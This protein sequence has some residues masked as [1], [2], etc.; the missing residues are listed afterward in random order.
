[1]RVRVTAAIILG[2]A[3]SACGGGP[4]NGAP[5]MVVGGQ[6]IKLTGHVYVIADRRVS[7]VPNVGIVVGDK[8]VLVIDTG[9]GPANAEI[10]LAEVRKI[11]DLPIQFLVSTHFHPEHYFG[12]QSFPEDTIIIVSTA[13]RRDLDNKG[14]AYREWFVDMF[15]DDVADLL[16]PVIIVPPDITFETRAEFDLGNFPVELYHFGYAAHTTGDTVVYLPGEKVLF[17]GGLTPNRF[18]PIL[19]D[20]DSSVDGWLASLDELATFDITHLVPGHG[21]VGDRD[22][23]ANVRNYLIEL[24]DAALALKADGVTLADAQAKLAPVFESE[25]PDWGEPFWINNAIAEIY[26]EAEQ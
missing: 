15:A 23:I 14:E 10:V 11:T 9:M 19:P 6:T 20:E 5:P 16:A 12:A 8:G 7:L 3:V 13:E 26:A 17:A 22:L 24:K 4:A 18:F 25:H 1:M 2:V 21:E